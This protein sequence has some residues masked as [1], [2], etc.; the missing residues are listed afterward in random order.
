LKLA[1]GSISFSPTPIPVQLFGLERGI[2]LVL[3]ENDEFLSGR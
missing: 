3:D 2:N 1:F